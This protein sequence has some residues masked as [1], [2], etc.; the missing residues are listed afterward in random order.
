M[1]AEWEHHV[2]FSANAFNQTANFCQVAGTVEG[3]VGGANDVDPRFFACWTLTEWFARRYFAQAIFAPQPIHGAVGALPLVFI[4]SARQEALNVGA[5]W[6]DAA[7][8][9]LSDG[10]CDHHGRQVG[11]QCCMSTLHGTFSA[12]A[13][14]LLFCQASHHNGQLVRWQ[15][16]GV[17]Q[18]R[19]DWQVLAAH[20]A[21]DHNLQTF[22]GG[23]HI[24]RAPITACAVM[25]Q[26]E[27]RLDGA[28]VPIAS[29]LRF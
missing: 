12:F 27:R 17:M 3:T 18:H 23:E 20:R 7:T 28:H 13:A 25:V 29:D 19:G 11:I 14:Q 4:D 26:N 5:F 24:H 8:D 15:A 16:I 10:A 6:R 2:D 21:V 22:D 9:H 1:T